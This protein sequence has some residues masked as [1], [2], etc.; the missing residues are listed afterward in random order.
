[1]DRQMG[2][3]S[4]LAVGTAVTGLLIAL[5]T[6]PSLSAPGAR[7]AGITPS[8]LAGVGI[9]ATQAQVR[10]RWG[11]PQRISRQ[12][13]RSGE[14]EYVYQASLFGSAG[15][16]VFQRGRSVHVSITVAGFLCT[17]K[18]DCAGTTIAEFRHHWP[19]ARKAGPGIY[20]LLAARA[21]YV[22]MFLFEPYDGLQLVDLITPADLAHCVIEGGTC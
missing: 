14:V 8:S 22:L 6:S 13:L 19:K 15:F 18:G 4:S 21:G 16:V 9:G 12:R 17:S 10:K 5:T 11:S 3:R 1:M 20:T 2:P 7:T